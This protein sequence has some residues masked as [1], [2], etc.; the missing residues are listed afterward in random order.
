MQS[1]SADGEDGTRE[2]YVALIMDAISVHVHAKHDSEDWLE[3]EDWFRSDDIDCGSFKH[4]CDALDLE[5][6][7]VL[8]VVE[9][10]TLETLGR[11]RI[12]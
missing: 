2:L 5:S 7:R 3:V 9:G 12:G 6:D 8:K 4:A 10:L 11:T 1:L